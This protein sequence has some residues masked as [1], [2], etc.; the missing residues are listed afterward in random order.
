MAPPALLVAVAVGLGT[1]DMPVPSVE[2][3]EWLNWKFPRPVHAGDTIYARWTLTQKR[4]PIGGAATSIVVWRVDLHTADGALCAEGEVGAK[5]RRQVA[6]QDRHPAQETAAAAAPRRRRGRRRPGSTTGPAA[7]N[8][9]LPEP[10]AIAAPPASVAKPE[11]AAG[12]ARRRRRRRP[13]G[14]AAAREGDAVATMA[15]PAEA[16]PPPDRAPTPATAERGG[17]SG[18]IR[19]LRR[20]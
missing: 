11:R 2:E 14:A 13:S 9:L 17:L 8:G 7:A 3:W 6:T 10:P 16:A 15:P 20:T 5:V 1:I 4:P 12:P 18:V 19:R